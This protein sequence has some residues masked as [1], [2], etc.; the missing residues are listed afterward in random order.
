MCFYAL[1]HGLQGDGPGHAL[2]GLVDIVKRAAHQLARRL[3]ARRRFVSQTGAQGVKDV[4]IR[5]SVKRP[6]GTIRRLRR[7]DFRQQ[8]A[9]QQRLDDLADQTARHRKRFGNLPHRGRQLAPMEFL[10]D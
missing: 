2:F 10:S 5:N 7:G 9:L 6:R 3:L 8:F 1:H 4:L